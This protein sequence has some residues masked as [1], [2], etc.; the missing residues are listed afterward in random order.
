MDSSA[1]PLRVLFVD[2]DWDARNIYRHYL[3]HRG[4]HTDTAVDGL[5]AIAQ[6]AAVKPDV[7][8]MDISMPLMEGHTAAAALRT[9]PAT[10]HIPIIA[11]S[12]QGALK[13]S[14][15][16][17]AV[18]DAVCW[19]PCRPQDLMDV[20]LRVASGGATSS[21]SRRRRAARRVP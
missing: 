13:R 8:V 17:L 21:P 5:D 16:R 3:T 2:D 19:K 6:A 7:I 20:I 15:T 18:F 12:A 14:K 10:R 1:T 11:F 4:L 9:D